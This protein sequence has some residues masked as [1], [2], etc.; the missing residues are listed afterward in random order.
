MSTKLVFANSTNS[1]IGFNIVDSSSNHNVST[2]HCDSYSTAS[3]TVSGVHDYK[4]LINPGG[5][6][7]S[8]RFA[9]DTEITFVIF[10]Q[11]VTDSSEPLAEEDSAAPPADGGNQYE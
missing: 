1:S 5:N 8:P 11:P 9:G 7:Y 3:G 6:F 10:T 4:V 2:F